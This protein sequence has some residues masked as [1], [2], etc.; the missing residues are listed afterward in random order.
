M[1]KNQ[2]CLTSSINVRVNNNENLFNAGKINQ[3][4]NEQEKSNFLGNNQTM[5]NNNL[6][7]LQK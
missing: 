4:Y 5:S 2:D 1:N 7:D 6:T 3:I